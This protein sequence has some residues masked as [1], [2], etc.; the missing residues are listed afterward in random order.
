MNARRGK[1]SAVDS[2]GGATPA[3]AGPARTGALAVLATPSGAFA[4][5]GGAALVFQ[6]WVLGRWV[7]GGGMHSAPSSGYRISTAREAVTWAAQG[8]IPVIALVMGLVIVRASR[9][10][11]RVTL[12][13]ALLLGFFLGF[14]QSPL[15]NYRQ[16]AILM[17]RYAVN[18]TTWGP[19]IPGWHGPDAGGQVETPLALSGVSFFLLILWYWVQGWATDRIAA[20]RPHWGWG[21]LLPASLLAGWAGAAAIELAW[22]STGLYSYAAPLAHLTLFPGHWYRLPLLYPLADAVF[23]STAPVVM[24]HEELARGRVPYVFRGTELLAL[25]SGNALRLLAGV[26]LANILL[27][28][29]FAACLLLSGSLAGPTSDAPSYLWPVGR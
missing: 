6:T 8:G 3:G 18:V 5:L 7:A 13:L 21:R 11:G 14:W 9:R 15:F 24:R 28:G 16:L 19:Y 29:Y 17:N 25:R 1:G 22:M 12:D 4:V 20:R 26:G 2:T 27:L 23:L 10:A